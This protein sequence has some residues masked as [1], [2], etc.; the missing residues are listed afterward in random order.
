ML[1][2]GVDVGDSETHSFL[3]ASGGWRL[4]RGFGGCALMIGSGC[5]LG[6]WRWML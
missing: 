6:G 3:V 2:G 4:V 5:R 1:A